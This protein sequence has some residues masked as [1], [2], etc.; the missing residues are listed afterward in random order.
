MNM[1]P[2]EMLKQMGSL[3]AQMEQMKS[4]MGRLTA[5]GSAGAGMVEISINGLYQVQKVTIAPEM[6][7]LSTDTSTLEVLVASAF[8]DATAKIR[9]SMEDFTK[10]KLAGMGIKQ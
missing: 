7:Q 10:S 3:N 2:F 1:N 5:T 6:L 8:N 9:A 4:E